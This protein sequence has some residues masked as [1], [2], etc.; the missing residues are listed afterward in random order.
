LLARATEWDLGGRPSNRLLSGSDIA[1]AK[2]WA[3]RRPKDAPP[4]TNLHLDFIK[5]S[6]ERET[7]RSSAER[8]QLD[9]MARAQEERAKALAA[10]EG[11]LS[12]EALAQSRRI[13]LRN[14]SLIAITLFAL[15]AGWGWLRAVA[16]RKVAQE[17]TTQA[18]TQKRRAERQTAIARQ[19]KAQAEKQTNLAADMLDVSTSLIVQLSRKKKLDDEDYPKV[20]TLF[21][22]GAEQGNSTSMGNLGAMYEGGLGIEKSFANAV[23]WYRKAAK[24]GNPRA[25]IYLGD[26]HLAGRHMPRDRDRAARWYLSAALAGN[27]DVKTTV[28]NIFLNGKGVGKNLKVARGLLGQAAEQGNVAAMNDLG[29]TYD[30]DT[31]ETPDYAT[32]RQWY[33]KAAGSGSAVAMSNLAVIYCNGK[34]TQK[35]MPKCRELSEKAAAIGNDASK[36][37]LKRL[38]YLAAEEKGDYVE[39]VKLREAFV[40]DIEARETTQ[41]GAPGKDTADSMLG[42]SWDALLARNNAKALAVAERAHKLDPSN[43]AIETNRAHALMFLHREMEAR[44]IYRQYKGKPVYTDNSKTWETVVAEDFVEFRKRGIAHPMMA[45]I[46]KEMSAS[47]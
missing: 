10:A 13:K 39:A 12:R 41:V 25:M 30:D 26:I 5:A 32:A 31:G 21:Q 11:A 9:L 45:E 3:A 29:T 24:L 40:A 42:L 36:L 20:L 22:K 15:V 8:Q 16:E 43:V 23:G 46:E 35:D 1:D 19:E 4:P 6:E 28:G 38:A 44:A 37:R 47:R 2:E 27:S 33:E 14:A 18:E 17:K 7:A 34:G